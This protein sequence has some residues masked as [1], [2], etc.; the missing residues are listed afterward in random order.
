METTHHDHFEFVLPCI[1]GQVNFFAHQ[2]QYAQL[3]ENLTNNPICK[4]ACGTSHGCCM[5]FD[6]RTNKL[7]FCIDVCRTRVSGLAFVKGGNYLVARSAQVNFLSTM[8]MYL[9]CHR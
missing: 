8:E 9:P 1:L 7:R 5:I 3:A 4:Q 2:Q 6:W